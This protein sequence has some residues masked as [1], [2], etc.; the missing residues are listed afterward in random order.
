MKTTAAPESNPH[1]GGLTGPFCPAGQQSYGVGYRILGAFGQIWPTWVIPFHNEDVIFGSSDPGSFVVAYPDSNGTGPWTLEAQSVCATPLPGHQGVAE[2]YPEAE[3][4]PARQTISTT[5]PLGKNV[6]AAGGRAVEIIDSDLNP[7][8][9]SML[10]AFAPD[11]TLTSVDVRAIPAPR[12][13]YTGTVIT[14]ADAQCATPPPGLELVTDVSFT[15]SQDKVRQAACP[16]SKFVIGSGAQ[17]VNSFGRVVLDSVD[18][19]EDL[20]DVTASGSEIEGGTSGSWSL[21]VYAICI[22]R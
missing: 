18:I 14:S 7:R 9:E 19:D 2:V 15:N 6:V 5:C 20:S 22:N 13:Q 1:F 4:A 21:R 8:G 11:S 10:E 12:P 17:I 3:Q 16:P